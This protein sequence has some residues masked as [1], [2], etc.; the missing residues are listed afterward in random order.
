L[1]LLAV[2]LVGALAL[3]G[4][5]GVDALERLSRSPLFQASGATWSFVRP[6]SLAGS[7]PLVVLRV[8]PAWIGA[9]GSVFW[10]L[11]GIGGGLLLLGFAIRSSERKACWIA[12]SLTLLTVGLASLTAT[13]PI[14]FAVSIVGV[15]LALAAGVV[16][17]AWRAGR[18]RAAAVPAEEPAPTAAAPEPAGG[19]RAGGA[20]TAALTLLLTGAACGAAWAGAVT[21]QVA[22]DATPVMRQIEFR[23]RGPGLAKNEPKVASVTAMM[24]FRA[25][26]PG[27]CRILAPP[28]VLTNFDLSSA[29]LSLAAGADGYRLAIADDGD[30]R[31]RLDFLAPVS[32]KDG[33]WSLTLP[34]LPNLRNTAAVRLPATGLDVQCAD[35]VLL[36]AVETNNATEIAVVFGPAASPALTWRPRERRTRLEKTAFFCEANTLASFEPGVVSMRHAVRYQIAQGELQSLG[37]AIP[38]G[39]SVTAVSAPG[40]STW[41]FDPESRVLEALLAKPVSADFTLYVTTQIPQ[42]SLPYTAVCAVPAV[43]DAVRQRGAVALMAPDSIQ[44]QVNAVTGVNAMAVGDFPLDASLAEKLGRGAAIKRAFRYQQLPVAVT[45]RADP[46]LPELR[47]VEDARLDISDERIVLSSKIELAISRSGVFAVTFRLPSEYEVESLGGQDVSHWDEIKEGGRGVRVYFD[48]QILGERTLNLVLART[49]KGIETEIAVPRL[50]VEDAVKHTG[51]LVVT[52]ERGVRLTTARRDGVSEINPGELGLTQPGAL[53]FKLL[54]PDWSLALK[55]EVMAPVIRAE[56]LQQVRLTEGLLLGRC[57]LNFKID[58]AGVK[59]F[60][61]RAPQTNLAL[62]ITGRNIARVQPVDRS[63]GL[64]QVELHNKVEK[65]YLMQVNYQAPREPQATAVTVAPLLAVGAESQKGYLVVMSSPRLRVIARGMPAGCKAEDARNIPLEFKAGDLSDAVLCY[66]TTHPEYA[67]DLDVVRHGS[68]EILPATVQRV[69]LQSVVA[70]DDHM[71]TRVTVDLRAGELRFLKTTLPPG[72]EVWSAFVNGRSATPLLEGAASLIP[73]DQAGAG[74]R[75]T[76]EFIYGGKAAA[77]AATRAHRCAG[78]QFD[79]P[80][81]DIE[82]TFYVPPARRY[83]GFGGT[84]SYRSD[85]GQ[86]AV[87]LFDDQKYL[88]DNAGEA[89]RNY[90]KAASIL[91]QGEQYVKE[92]RQRD[93]RKAFESA[94]YYSQGK[95]D[96]NED[97]RVQ[98]RNLARQQAVVGLVNRRG[99]L[100][101]AQNVQQP[102]D[103]R[104]QRQLEQTVEGGEWSADYAQQVAQSLSVEDNDA[105]NVVAEKILDQQE[106]AAG[107]A[108]PIRIT[109]P[110]QGRRL[111]FVRLL[112]IKPNAELSV[113]YR[114]VSDRALQWLAVAGSVV[115]MALV[116]RL[117]AGLIV[118]RR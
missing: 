90:Q 12:G 79:L 107:L 37:L 92:G 83:F 1:L 76:V 100:R 62:A 68:A 56:V 103:G 99:A 7:E 13:R 113:S 20:T 66:R 54:R 114:A 105:L 47:A 74:G 51:S 10:A 31:V 25:E 40:L 22:G 30:Y 112:Q 32:E 28:N 45:A 95:A 55:T 21:N 110:L 26:R 64:W 82:W 53:A 44:I 86:R 69:R 101:S 73:L 75:T 34:L 70:D 104:Q 15:P 84:V 87:F 77:G 9:G 63:Q 115:L 2:L 39:M 42:E 109:V 36:K 102:D 33:Q 5:D 71:V 108:P 88:A 46:V 89:E 41:R 72:S 116:Y 97:V 18:R 117:L 94:L 27:A 43:A 78:P 38:A 60:T 23:V 59:V 96:F 80:L 6:V 93:A 35:A 61:L 111:Q 118:R 91:K 19:S 49:E 3:R 4:S 58:N 52:G 106:A 11:V 85:R 81:T 24:E 50:I 98:Y 8:L 67:L 65:D 48:K 29:D 14:V 17:S 16:L 57:T